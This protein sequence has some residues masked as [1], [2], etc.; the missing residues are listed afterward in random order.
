M[1]PSLIEGFTNWGTE[2]PNYVKLTGPTPFINRHWILHGR[3]SA[4]GTVADALSLFNALQT[5]DSL[6]E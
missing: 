1:C 5:I 2:V 4:T 3:D 6:L